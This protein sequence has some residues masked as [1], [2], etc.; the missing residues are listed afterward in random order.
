MI[1]RISDVFGVIAKRCTV[2]RFTDPPVP[3]EDL[4]KILRAARRREPDACRASARLRD[5]I[6]D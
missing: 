6:R 4:M 3:E 1:D 2:R 5:H